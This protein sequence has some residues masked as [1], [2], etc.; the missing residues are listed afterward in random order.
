MFGR[1]FWGGRFFGARYWGDGGTGSAQKTSSGD[2]QADPAVVAGTAVHYTLH[3]SSGALSA[4]AAQVAGTATHY[5][6]HTATGDLVSDAATISGEAVDETTFVA[7]SRQTG[8]GRSKKPRK[9]KYQVEVD[10]EVF[11]VASIEEA[12][13]VLEKVKE[14]ADATAKLAVERANKAK[15]RP[16]RQVIKD[17]KRTLQVPE[18][19][20]PPDLRDMANQLIGQIK[21]NYESAISAIEIGARMARI[22]R[23]I[24]EDDE[25]LMMLL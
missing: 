22:E 7:P 13:E 1:R 8:A 24:D 5:T 3:T 17:A 9:R 4:D 18:V 15:R 11:D 2:L 12:E 20:V 19:V 23:D 6:L 25:E 21:S 14:K 10:G 16:L